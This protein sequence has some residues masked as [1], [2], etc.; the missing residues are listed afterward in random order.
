MRKFENTIRTLKQGDRIVVPK[1]SIKWIQHHAIYLGQQN[2]IDWFIENKEGIGVRTVTAQV[3]FF[4]VIEVTRIEMFKPSR[5]YTS[6]DLV[7]R[8]LKLVGKPYKLFGYNCESL[9]NHLQYGVVKS[10][11][12]NLGIGLGVLAI[13]AIGSLISR[14]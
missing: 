9:A 10:Q 13:A 7:N 3:F 12:A 11:Q 14:R 4:D 1:S 5:N 8:A 2:G 6:R